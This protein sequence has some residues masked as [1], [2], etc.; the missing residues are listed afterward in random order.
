[1]TLTKTCLGS[2]SYGSCYLGSFRAMNVMVKSSH[3]HEKK[4]ESCQQAENRVRQK[5][6]YEA[7]IL[8]KLG[9]HPGLPF[10]HGV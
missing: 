1:M 3:V 7:H 6:I 4:D 9:Y 8:N 10:L 2:G 5:L